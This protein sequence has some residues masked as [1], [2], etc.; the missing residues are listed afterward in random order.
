MTGPAGYARPILG[1]IELRNVWFRYAETEPF[2]LEDINL[3]GRA[4]PLW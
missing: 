4:R 1:R 3:V 2:V